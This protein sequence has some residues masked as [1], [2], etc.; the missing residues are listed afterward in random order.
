M[1]MEAAKTRITSIKKIQDST[2]DTVVCLVEIY[3]GNLGRRYELTEPLVTVGRDPDNGIVIDTDS[4]SRRHA[5]IE[6]KKGEKFIVDLQS[7]NGS[8]L[9]DNMVF[10]AQLRNGD[11]LKIGDTIFKFLS[12]Q[13]IESA[14][15]EEI[16]RMTI[17]D[18]LTQVHNKRYLLEFLEGEFSRARRY[19]RPLSLIMLDLDH[20]KSIN[21]ENGHLTGD[22]VLKETANCIRE[23][24][25]REE[26]FA[27]YGGEEF[28]IV[29]PETLLEGAIEFADIVRE[30]VGTHTFLFEGN[31]IPVTLSCGVAQL[32]DEMKTIRDLIRAADERLFDAKRDGRNTVK[33]PKGN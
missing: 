29:L 2:P 27:R 32:T 6:T 1:L 9:N 28:T 8:Y 30:M 17:Q 21:D 22:F 5:Q 11:L 4:V 23:R 31:T 3:G 33:P 25:R 13:N 15:H 18:G 19:E 20:F 16:Y 26:L 10:R 12:G 14:Y 7:T 24:I